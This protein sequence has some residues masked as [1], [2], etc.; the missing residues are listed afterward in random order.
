MKQ[1]VSPNLGVT[2]YP[3]YC[4]RMQQSVWGAPVRY[5]TAWEA[6]QNT[7]Y[8]HV[9][10]PPSDV[11]SVIWFDHWGTYG[12][13]YGQY[14][15]VATYVPGQGI[16]SNPARGNGQ[17]WYN[18]IEQ[19]ARDC[20]ATYVGW[21]E[22]INGLRVIE[23]GE[24][25][26]PEEEED[27]A[28]GAFYRVLHGEKNSGGIWWQ[29]KPN[30]PLIKISELQTWQAYAA[31]GNKYCDLHWVDIETLIKKYGTQEKPSA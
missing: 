11:S 23:P 14:G 10:T 28:I 2:D 21:T 22:D 18:T 27:M 31:N 16:L 1:L 30:L 3:G 8:K 26:K 19:C 13:V 12:G 17:K 9:G 15:H 5:A 29:E 4:L 7:Q 24:T 6:W 20:N 25:P